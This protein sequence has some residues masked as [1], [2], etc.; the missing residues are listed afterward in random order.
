MT[1]GI[2]SSRTPGPARAIG[3][4]PSQAL[5]R[6]LESSTFRQVDRLKHFLQFIVTETLEGRG[7]QLKEYVIGV[8]V[9]DKESSF[10]PRVD[11]IVRV[12]ARRL[13]SRLERYY[14]AEGAGDPLVVDLPKGGYTP[15][16]RSRDVFSSNRRPINAA[17]AGHNTIA[18]ASF[19]DH[20]QARDLDYFCRGVRQEIIHTLAQSPVL[21]VLTVPAELRDPARAAEIPTPALTVTGGV[22]SSGKRLRVTVHLTDSATGCCVWSHSIDGPIDDP[23][24]LQD[25][26]AAAVMA[27]LEPRIPDRRKLSRAPVE[28]L[29]ARNLNLQG[30]YHL[31]QR[32]DE[33][34][35]KAVEFFEKA[36]VEDA[37]YSVAHSG[38]A[39]AYSLL[40]HYGVL[41]PGRAWA[42]A[43]S[44]AATAVLLD[45]NCAEARTSLAHV[46]ATQEWDW[47]SAEREFRLAI[48]LDPSYATAHHWYAVSCLVPLGRLD[49]ALDAMLLAQSLDPVS[50][51]VA[52]DLALVHVYR[53]D[54]DAALDQC[55]HA[56]ALNPHFSPAYWALGFTQE[57]RGDLDEAAAAFQRAIHLAPDSPRIQ[58]SLARTHALAGR[59]S[60]AAGILKKLEKMAQQRYVSPFEF[61]LIRLALGEEDVALEW[62]AQ[63]TR[64]RAFDLIALRVDP[65]FD[66]LRRNPR[67]Q[68]ILADLGYA[69][70]AL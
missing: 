32:T 39:D 66:T 18:V 44:L 12:Q 19:A 60:R 65:R 8:Q 58:A 28:N 16:F 9:F 17:L 68:P 34:L 24:G 52:R 26:T 50:S 3:P 49:E 36:I 67:L 61:A 45:G 64:D 4:P 6:I 2:M 47:V 7:D 48:N 22:R 27:E 5:A 54:L 70:A 10:D 30:R 56:I 42:K 43:A 62:L 63:A 23:L 31:N 53:K 37:Q 35:I 11:P 15:V 59:R 46:K 55:D 14:Q 41:G 38:L 51:I 69:D 25:A 57:Q 13:R 1:A 33:G 20:S 40:A 21:R 29:A